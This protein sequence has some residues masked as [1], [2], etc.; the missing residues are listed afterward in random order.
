MLI[1]ALSAMLYPRFDETVERLGL[2]FDK[3]MV[4][5]ILDLLPS[6]DF[7]WVNMVYAM[8]EL[9]PQWRFDA[10]FQSYNF[11]PFSC[12]VSTNDYVRCDGGVVAAMERSQ[13]GIT[14]D[15]LL[16]CNVPML[17]MVPLQVYIFV[18][19]GFSA[20]ALQGISVGPQKVYE[21]P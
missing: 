9:S 6:L 18:I 7:A 16:D 3:Y 8:V 14:D 11:G 21:D 10:V 1:G 4:N 12:F 2:V 13:H 20:E 5:H 15:S 19:D 17:A